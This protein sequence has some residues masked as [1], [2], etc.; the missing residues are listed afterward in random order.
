MMGGSIGSS[1]VGYVT[2][3]VAAVIGGIILSQFMGGG[4]EEKVA[5]ADSATTATTA[6]ASPP[7]VDA[8]ADDLKSKQ[9]PYTYTDNPFSNTKNATQ[10][11]AAAEVLSSTIGEGDK[12]EDEGDLYNEYEKKDDNPVDNSSTTIP[13]GSSSSRLPEPLPLHF[14]MINPLANR[15]RPYGNTRFTR[16]TI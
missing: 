12:E 4:E 11:R 6:D 2:A 9:T 3:T 10:K 14:N 15:H 1:G 7:L 16:Y 5:A 13:T 8:N